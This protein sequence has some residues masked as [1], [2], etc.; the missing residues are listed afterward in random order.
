[1]LIDAPTMKVLKQLLTPEQRAYLVLEMIN[2]YCPLTTAQKA[3]LAGISE[4]GM[5]K[6]KYGKTNRQT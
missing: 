5:Q 1:M 4:R 3:L 2:P 6:R